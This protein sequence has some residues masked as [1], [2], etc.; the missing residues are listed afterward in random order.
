VDDRWVRAKELRQM[1]KADWAD[2]WMTKHED[3]IKAE[4]VSVEDFEMLFVDRG[5]IIHATR[6]YRPLSFRE[7]LEKH[8]GSE[9]ASRVDI[10]PNVGGWRKFAKQNFP[11][12]RRQSK[13]EKPKIKVDLSQHQRKAGKGWLNKAR[14]YKKIRRSREEY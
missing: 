5:E 2:L 13:R 8:V 9:D 10:D 4:G 7:I 11:A 1:L 12:R 3:E 14:I 6:D